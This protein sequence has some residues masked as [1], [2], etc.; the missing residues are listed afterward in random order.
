M[1]NAV[2][3][4]G[5]TAQA[6]AYLARAPKSNAAYVAI[7]EAMQDVRDRGSLRPPPHLR[8]ASY[9]GAKKLG[10][11]VGYRYPHDYPDARVDQQYLPD[12]L[13]G[14]TYYPDEP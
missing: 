8:D 4:V 6:V 7:S 2:A 14:R 12:E 11:G 10:H 3:N 5:S 9:P 13:V 1:A